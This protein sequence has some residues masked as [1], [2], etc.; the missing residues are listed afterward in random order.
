MLK[1]ILYIL[2]YLYLATGGCYAVKVMANDPPNYKY[3]VINIL[4]A[5]LF[6]LIEVFFW[7]PMIFA[8]FIIKY[9]DN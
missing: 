1:Y 5:I 9:V 8:D 2:L 4:F 3:T 7:V 6:L